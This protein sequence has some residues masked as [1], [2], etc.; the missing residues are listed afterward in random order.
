[1]K[2]FKWNWTNDHAAKKPGNELPPIEHSAI[3]VVGGQ[4]AH[5]NGICK[6]MQRN[7]SILLRWEETKMLDAPTLMLVCP[8]LAKKKTLSTITLPFARPEYFIWHYYIFG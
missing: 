2:W 1:L 8:N 3:N 5:S 7:T 4:G 6:K